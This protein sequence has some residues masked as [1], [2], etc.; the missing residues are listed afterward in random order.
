MKGGTGGDMDARK[1]TYVYILKI[2][3]EAQITSTSDESTPLLG[4]T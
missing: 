1:I 2:N 4:A 3:S